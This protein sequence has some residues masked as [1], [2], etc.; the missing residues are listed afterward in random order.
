MQEDPESRQSRSVR[1]R[2]WLA[3]P[4]LVLGA[5]GTLACLAALVLAWIASARLRDGFDALFDRMHAS[6]DVVGQRIVQA[7]D[8]IDGATKSADELEATIRD[9]VGLDSRAQAALR[10]PAAERAERV[11]AALNQADRWLETSESAVGLVQD[12]LSMSSSTGVSTEAT[13]LDQLL[14]TIASL[15]LQ[16]GEAT[17]CMRKIRE[18]LAEPPDAESREAR[19]GTT[20]QLADRAMTVLASVESGLEKLSGRSTLAQGRLLEIRSATRRHIL[21]VTWAVTLLLAWMG[22]G[23]VAL[24]LLAWRRPAR[25]SSASR[26]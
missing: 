1:G 15:R 24:C 26:T 4:G 5:L 11:S 2:S 7:R 19:T 13:P 18:R 20:L 22:A 16:L 3:V 21:I 14:E 25:A 12:R 23:Q 10:A 6:L 9:R 8:G 17:D